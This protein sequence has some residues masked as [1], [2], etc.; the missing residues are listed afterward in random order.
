MPKS[1]K[2][3]GAKAHRKRVQKRNERIGIE[4]KQFQKKFT[5]MYEAK[6]KEIEEQ[7]NKM[8]AQTENSKIGEFEPEI[9]SAGFTHEDNF[10]QFDQETETQSTTTESEGE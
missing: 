7:F 5:E 10:V 9:D 6:Y 3:G 1:R 4:K 2:R 8:T